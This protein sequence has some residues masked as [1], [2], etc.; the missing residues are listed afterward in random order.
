MAGR[1][2]NIS[3]LSVATIKDIIYIGSICVAIIFFFVDKGKERAVLDTKI[4]MIIENQNN[5]F[6][7]LKE[8]DGKFEKQAEING[9]I[10]LYI[11]L[12]SGN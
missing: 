1:K 12:D 11:E 8:T 4:N 10:I 3:T 2:I 5:I 6:E 9:K 7:K